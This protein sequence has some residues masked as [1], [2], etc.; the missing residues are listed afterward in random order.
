MHHHHLAVNFL[1]VFAFV[2]VCTSTIHKSTSLCQTHICRSEDHLV[3][4]IFYYM[5]PVA[6]T[7]II[8]LGG[9]HPYPLSHLCG[10]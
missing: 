7:Q 3:G 4:V 5:D 8:R 6:Q 10:P 2:I 1:F 9:K